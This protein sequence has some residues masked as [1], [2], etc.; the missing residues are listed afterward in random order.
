[1]SVPTTIGGADGN[2]REMPPSHGTDDSSHFDQSQSDMQDYSMQSY[3]S[4]SRRMPDRSIS[5]NSSYQSESESPVM[6]RSA[7]SLYQTTA[8]QRPMLTPG[9]ALPPKSQSYAGPAHSMGAQSGDLSMMRQQLQQMRDLEIRE[10]MQQSSSRRTSDSSNLSQSMHVQPVQRTASASATLSRSMH[11]EAGHS[12]FG[13]MQAGGPPF[14]NVSIA[15][16]SR[17]FKPSFNR[18]DGSMAGS[19]NVNEAMEKLC[20]SM[21]RSAMS[22]CLVKQYSSGRGVSRHGSGSLY[23]MRQAAGR[24]NAMD[25]SSGR[26]APIRRLSSAKHQLH[27]PARGVYRHDSQGANSTRSVNLQI[28]GRN[29]GAL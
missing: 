26:S 5:S 21:K 27:H 25:D 4:P 14:N 10:T 13:N 8:G 19:S 11:F 9:R 6:G 18:M 28:D 29:M 1:M 24:S 16:D 2:F 22:R 23:A 17:S 7:S 3:R 20:E 15:S 12:S